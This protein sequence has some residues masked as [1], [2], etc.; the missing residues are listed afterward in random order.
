M[1]LIHISAPAGTFSD[2][3]RDRLAD[4]LTTITLTHGGLPLTPF[5]RSTVWIY[6][7]EFASTHVYHGG[8]PGVTPVI[9]VEINAFQGGL[10]AATKPAIIRD[11]TDVITRAARL[12]QDAPA[13]VYILFRHIPADDWGVFGSTITLDEL[14][15]SDPD[16]LPLHA[17]T[18]SSA[19]GRMV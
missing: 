15:G 1:P 18:D 14:R 17:L 4:N 5:V 16:G 6:F 2:P 7:H 10:N 8:Q 13:P 3:D 19:A 12:P 9:S 11:V